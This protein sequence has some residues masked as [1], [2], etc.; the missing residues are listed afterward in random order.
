MRR[1]EKL[2]AKSALSLI[3]ALKYL[4]DKFKN[5]HILLAGSW[6]TQALSLS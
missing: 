2:P 1:L 3:L 4:L 5:A 6:L